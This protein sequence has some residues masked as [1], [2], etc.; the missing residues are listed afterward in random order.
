MSSS[1]APPPEIGA[2]QH[3]L[4]DAVEAYTM[5]ARDAGDVAPFPANREVGPTE[6]AVTAAAML[7]AAGINSFEIAGLFNV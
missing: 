7:K 2:V 6:V 3:Q 4:A 1:D 5:L